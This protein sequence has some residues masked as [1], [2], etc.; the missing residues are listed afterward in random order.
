MKVRL[1][2]TE[3]RRVNDRMVRGIVSSL[4]KEVWLRREGK[5][6][7]QRKRRDLGGIFFK[8]CKVLKLF[9]SLF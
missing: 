2:L 5:G 4:V 1:G 7:R 8:S 6:L 9:I 3:E